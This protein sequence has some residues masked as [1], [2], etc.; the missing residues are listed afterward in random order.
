MPI[1]TVGEYLKRWGYTAKKPAATP[2]TRTP[3]RSNAGWRQP[4]R[5]PERGPAGRG[6]GSTGA[7]RPARPPTA[8]RRGYSRKGQ[9]ATMEVPEPHIRMNM[10][11]TIGDD[12]MVRFMTYKETMTG[13]CSSFSWS[14]CSTERPGSFT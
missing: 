9:P 4:S 11:S 13:D 10:I 3:P 7:T 12:G 1:R 2:A 6:R 14:G 8:P 5:R